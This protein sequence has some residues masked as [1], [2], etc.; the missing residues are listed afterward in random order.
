MAAPQGLA[1][2]A[3]ALICTA[4][5]QCT[6]LPLVPASSRSCSSQRL[7]KH[8]ETQE[9]AGGEVLDLEGV[10]SGLQS[11]KSRCDHECMCWSPSAGRPGGGCWELLWLLGRAENTPG[12]CWAWEATAD[13]TGVLLKADILTSDPGDGQVVAD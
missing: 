9:A 2:A 4:Q 5:H 7:L 3:P 8:R 11:H 13:D 6:D 1:A 12:Y 10:S